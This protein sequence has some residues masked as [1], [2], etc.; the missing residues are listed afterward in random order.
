MACAFDCCILKLLCW[1]V[2][3]LILVEILYLCRW[4]D[5]GNLEVDIRLYVCK[6]SVHEV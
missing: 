5:V 3:R 6:D 4:L 2:D 1:S